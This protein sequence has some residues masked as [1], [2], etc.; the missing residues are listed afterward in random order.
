MNQQPVRFAFA[1]TMQ[2]V[3]DNATGL[4]GAQGDR[5]RFQQG[6]LECFQIEKG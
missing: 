3:N 1:C 6:G 5:G 4:Q 2:T